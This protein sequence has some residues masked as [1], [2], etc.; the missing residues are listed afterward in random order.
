M[1]KDHAF[2][3]AVIRAELVKYLTPRNMTN[4]CLTCK[5]SF[6]WFVPHLW[7]TRAFYTNL[8]NIPG[9]KRYQQYV[10][11]IEDL[12]INLAVESRDFWAFPNL[13]SVEFVQH[14]VGQYRGYSGFGSYNTPVP[15]YSQHA[16][17]SSI[18]GVNAARVDLRL[19]LLLRSVPLLQDLT[20]T[21]ALDNS[22]VFQHF[23]ASLQS[24]T[25]L[26]T[27]KMT[28]NEY[29]NPTH[30]HRVIH[31]SRRCEE[32]DFSFSG[33]DSF[34][35]IEEREEY[36]QA[37]IDM[38][39]M[40]DL[41]V[42][43]LKLATTLEDQ[44]VAIMVPLLKKCPLLEELHM[45]TIK[46]PETV[47]LLKEA[48]INGACPQLSVFHPGREGALKDDPLP[49]LLSVMGPNRGVN[50][51][52]LKKIKIT[53]A[54]FKSESALA[55]TEHLSGSLTEVHFQDHIMNFEVFNELVTGLPLLQ[56]IRARINEISVQTVD[57]N[58]FDQMC[59][60]DWVCLG[61]KTLQLGSQL[62]Q[63]IPTVKGD[64]WKQS[65]PKRCMDY[66]FSQFAKLEQLEEWD[67]VAGPVD[68]FVLSA[69]GYLRQLSE[70]KSLKKLGLG[71][72]TV[73]RMGAKEAEWVAENWTSLENVDLA[74]DSI[75]IHII[76]ISR[77]K[78][79]KLALDTFIHTLRSK[80]PKT[81][82]KKQ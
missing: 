38:E 35:G 33:V 22:D 57:I 40:E 8:K 11:V 16:F 29:V 66:M 56:S 30:I 52:G 15:S 74:C 43:T 62:T 42:K 73:Y 69:G 36:E 77:I 20:I 76:D 55:M 6:D 23:L 61:L 75:P 82:F 26:R 2:D 44:E 59:S 4:L 64:S 3:D 49:V 32:L 34:K 24:L 41:A 14:S 48:F 5:Q 37:R 18:G 19:V 65:L 79:D 12:A 25:Q 54:Q 50:A 68:L 10:K 72:R 7:H 78:A 17:G 21:L 1:E 81:S 71:P 13:Q 28:C 46:A 58:K 51:V 63:G 27:L 53:S 47:D 80:R 70:L 39:G 45:F 60:R 9:L 67:F 31:A